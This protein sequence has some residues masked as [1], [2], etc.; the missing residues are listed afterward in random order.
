MGRIVRYVL[1]PANPPRISPET[2]ARLDAMTDEELTANALS[3][4]DNPPLTEA[5]IKHVQRVH[6]LRRVRAATGLGQA[7]FAERFGFEA[8]R[9]AGLELGL[10]KPDGATEAFFALIEKDADEAASLVAARRAVG[11]VAAE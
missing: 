7:A 3:D 9:L 10:L 11:A 4:P 2:E 5:E 1:D 8:E 6:W